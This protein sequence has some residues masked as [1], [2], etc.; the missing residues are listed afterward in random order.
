[1]SNGELGLSVT[2]LGGTKSMTELPVLPK[3]GDG[4]CMSDNILNRDDLRL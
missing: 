1:M 4:E 2:H 3:L